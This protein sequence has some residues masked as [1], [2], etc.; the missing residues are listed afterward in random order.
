MAR[1][2]DRTKKNERLKL[3]RLKRATL[4]NGLPCKV[5]G[6]PLMDRQRWYC[7]RDCSAADVARCTPAK[8][9]TQRQI[10]QRAAEIRAGWTDAIREARR[11]IKST[12][13][14]MIRRFL[15]QQSRGEFVEDQVHEGENEPSGPVPTDTSGYRRASFKRE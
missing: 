13:P 2:V 14:V 8:I 3:W 6:A 15:F 9:P 5:C 4:P 7:S 10:K 1:V 11:V 12:P